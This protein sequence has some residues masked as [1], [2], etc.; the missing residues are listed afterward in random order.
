MYSKK[1]VNVGN[2]KIGGNNPIVIQSMTNTVTSDIY[3]TTEQIKELNLAGSEIVRIAVR[4]SSDAKAISE[5]K[6]KTDIP[7][8]AD[9]HFDY[10]LAIESIKNGIDKIRINPGNIGSEEKV[11]EVVKAAAEYNIPIRVGANSGSVNKNFLSMERYKALAESALEQVKILEKNNFGNIVV[12]IKSS[13]V[14]E[15]VYANR[16]IVQKIDY[17]IHLGVTEAGI[18][19]DSII[20]SSAGIGSLLIDGIGDTIRVSVTGDPLRE[21]PVAKKILGLLNFTNEVRVIS[22]PTCGRTEIE[23]EKLVET[24]KKSV[25]DIKTN[26]KITIAVMG[27]VVNGPGEASHADLAL[28]GTRFGAALYENGNFV[29][30]IKKEFIENEIKEYIAKK[31]GE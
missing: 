4:D 28:C 18:M 23:I 6:K 10:K 25:S 8:V 7:L 14:K 31:W 21:I 20:L 15:T 12:S 17:P 3:K 22:C 2:V 5:I 9:I 26:Q 30:N 29:M 27:C 19:E 11:K 1:T 13:D 24:V 16:Y